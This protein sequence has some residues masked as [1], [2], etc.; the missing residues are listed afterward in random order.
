MGVCGLVFEL[1]WDFDRDMIGRIDGVLGMKKNGLFVF[2]GLLVLVCLGAYM[3]C[4]TVDYNQIAVVKTFNHAD[5]S[6]VKREAGIYFKWPRPFQTVEFVSSSLY[7]LDAPLQNQKLRDENLLILKCYVNWKITDPI[8]F[9]TAVT[10]EAHASERLRTHVAKAV[11]NTVGQR[12]ITEFF[13]EQGKQPEIELEALK[14][15]QSIVSEQ[16]YGIEVVHLGFRRIEL[17]AS[18]TGE[19]F[20]SMKLK[21]ETIAKRVKV[22]GLADAEALKT[23]ADN[24]VKRVLAFAKRRA[25]SIRSK[26]RREKAEKLKEFKK[27]P[28]LALFLEKMETLE[29]ALDT[30]VPGISV[31]L[32]INRI[33]GKEGLGGGVMGGKGGKSLGGD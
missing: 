9:S 10:D 30:A 4:F 16:G 1:D 28:E 23:H 20:K 26:G 24:A 21:S 5:D 31:V 32:P 3:C 12:V 2:I 22:K 14:Q 27:N 17:H 19:V 7:V 33:I 8:L 25:E 11:S 29:A 15:L 13:G 6:D 18:V